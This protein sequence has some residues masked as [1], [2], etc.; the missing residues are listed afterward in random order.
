MRGSLLNAFWQRRRIIMAIKLKSCFVTRHFALRLDIVLLAAETNLEAGIL[1]SCVRSRTGYGL[2]SVDL[3]PKEEL[4]KQN[5]S[6]RR[7]EV[8]FT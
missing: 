1:D 6:L 8:A 5:C 3:K 7:T 4:R 2:V